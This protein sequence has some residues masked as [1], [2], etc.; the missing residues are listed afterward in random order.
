MEGGKGKKKGGEEDKEGVKEKGE[1][2]KEEGVFIPGVLGPYH[3][4]LPDSGFAKLC[5]RIQ[6]QVLLNMRCR[7]WI[8]KKSLN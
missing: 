7:S 1:G 6:I 2:K 3:Q 8:L 4:E 5:S